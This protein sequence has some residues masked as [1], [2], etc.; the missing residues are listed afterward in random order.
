LHVIT[1]ECP[2]A[3]VVDAMLSILA[4]TG[5][6]VVSRIGS[7][8]IEPV[9]ENGRFSGTYRA[10]NVLYRGG[11]VILQ[12]GSGYSSFVDFICFEGTASLG[13]QPVLLMEA[14]KTDD[15]ESRNTGI[16][17]R[18]T[19]FVYANHF[20]PGVRQVMYFDN[21]L[22]SRPSTSATHDFGQRLFATLGVEVWRNGVRAAYAPFDSVSELIQLKSQMRKP[23]AGNVPTAVTLDAVHGVKVSARLVKNDRLGHDP[24]IGFV[25]LVAGAIR[26]LGYSG[27]ITISDHGL[28][29]AYDLTSKNKMSYVLAITNSS[30]DGLIL[31]AVKL[32]A[33]YWKIET[34]QE[35]LCTILASILIDYGEGAAIYENHGGGERGYLYTEQGLP[36]QVPKTYKIPDLVSFDSVTRE[37]VVGEGKQDATRNAGV[38]DLQKLGEFIRLVGDTY[39]ASVVSKGLYLFGDAKLEDLSGFPQLAMHLASDGSVHLGPMAPSPIRRALAA[40]QNK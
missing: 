6:G 8:G 26:K 25:T 4:E 39:D 29:N 16:Y 18:G 35:K 27:S 37:I 11:A 34:H 20:F 12:I 28:P 7:V 30:L 36:I 5:N 24:N 14:T 15:S 32:P 9:F 17:Q 2:K 21:A 31:G 22:P 13:K 10:T 3:R 38:S 19:K 23:P 40:L 33:N 1:E